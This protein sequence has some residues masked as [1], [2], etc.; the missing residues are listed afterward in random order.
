MTWHQ[1][2]IVVGN[3]GGDP[4]L[5]YYAERKRRLQF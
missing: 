2:I 4:E 3:L 1:T 5:R